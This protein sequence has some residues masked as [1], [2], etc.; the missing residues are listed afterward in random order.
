M[1]TNSNRSSGTQVTPKGFNQGNVLVDPNTGLPI[2]VVT[3]G[4]GVRRLA[5]DASLDVGSAT[6]DVNLDV[7]NDGVHIGDLNT[8]DTLTINPDGS[9]DANVEV[10]AK[11]GDNI[12]ISSHTTSIF[13]EAADVIATASFKQ[14]Y[15]YTS[16]DDDTRIT[17]IE[18]S[19]STPSLIRLKV[20]GTIKRVLRSSPIERNVNFNFTEHLPLDDG[21][22]LTVEAKVERFLFSSYDSFVSL[23]GYLA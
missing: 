1:G 9:I 15:S 8:G 13:D 16:S 7:D 10:D 3:D 17:E 4:S 23:Q 2:D 18:C 12:A 21:D 5:V 19:V 20:N 22:V 6:L 11:D 14:I